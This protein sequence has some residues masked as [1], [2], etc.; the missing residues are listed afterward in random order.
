MPKKILL[1][2]DGNHQ[3]ILNLVLWLKKIKGAH[4]Q[5]DIF[6]F[7]PVKKENQSYFGAIYTIEE[8]KRTY[9]I[10]D[11]LWGLRRYYRFYLYTR[12]FKKLGA[13]DYIHFHFISVD[14][15]FFADYIRDKVQSKILFSIWGSDLYRVKKRDENKFLEACKIADKITFT[16]DKALEFFKNTFSWKKDN[17]LICRFGLAPL[18][19][20]KELSI[21]KR[22]C[23]K[24][25]EWNTDK[26][27]VV[28]GY[29]LSPAQ[30]H[31]EILDCFL[32]QNMVGF[33]DKVQLIV[34]ITYQGTEKYK[35]QIL[36]KLKQL[37]FEH[38]VYEN[39]M[40]DADV[41]HLRKASD[42][43][44]QLQK[45]DQFSGSMQEHLYAKNIVITGSWLPYETLKEEGAWFLEIDKMEELKKVLPDA[46]K[47]Y[48]A[49][50][51]ETVQNAEVI[52]RLSL[53][54][55][56]IGHWKALYK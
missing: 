30:Q 47:N 41:A 36:N 8:Y 48:E 4:Y 24:I 16:N 54:E 5:I 15:Y 45:T 52:A 2:G 10:V 56:T 44:I 34:P 33:K 51:P 17:L 22:E 43:M 11:K 32:D 50:V 23:K 20:L 21:S 3:F 6:S 40:T 18:Q 7:N 12:V 9:T 49:Y 19:T 29:N 39:F 38:T 1:V 26:L 35:N 42:V 14:S 53:W 13:Y 25:L 37:P 27:A 28:I 46:L 55:H 31:L